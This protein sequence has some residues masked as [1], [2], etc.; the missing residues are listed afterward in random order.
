M[1]YLYYPGCS[2]ESTA[3]E[4]NV[5]T[6]AIMRALGCE[7]EEIVGWNC[8]GA[9]AAETSSKLLSL[10]LSARV[11]A[12]AEKTGQ[13]DDILIPCSGCY[14]NLKKAEDNIKH[15]PEIKA[16][17]KEVLAEEDLPLPTRVKPRHLL[18]VIVT[19][20][21]PESI[22]K[23]RV[24]S[25]DGLKIAP[26]YGCQ[27]IRPFLV[28]DDPE[29]PRSMEPLIEATGAE[30]FHWDMGAKCCGAS[31]MITKQEIA[32]KLVSGILSAA[33][34]AD[35][36]VTVCGMCQMNLEAHQKRLSH[37]EGLDL[38]IPIL[39]FPQLL[40]LALGLENQ[41]VRLDLN[42]SSLHDFSKKVVNL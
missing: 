22:I 33:S 30:I 5:S 3:L 39:Y 19:D 18:D 31:N 1:K 41:D 28:F 17:I 23:K 37:E 13:S 29:D 14:L 42:L 10:V 27:C 8:C 6:R 20:L 35:A 32:S 7:L 2:L 25:L 4:Y 16:K 12:L 34:G 21:G 24:R 36:I 40:G 15:N 38:N 9:S 11:L 26:F